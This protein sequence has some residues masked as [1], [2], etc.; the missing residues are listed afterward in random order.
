MLV[1]L[2]GIET[3]QIEIIKTEYTQIQT[4]HITTTAQQ[5]EVIQIHHTLYDELT[6]NQKEQLTG[7]IMAAAGN[8]SYKGKY[9]V[10][11]VLRNRVNKYG[12]YKVLTSG[13][14]E[15]PFYITNETGY[16]LEQRN[17]QL[18][19]ARQAFKIAFNN[20]DYPNLMYYQNPL[21]S[22]DDGLAFFSKLTYVL[23]EGGHNFYKEQ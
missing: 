2:T 3:Q 4:E 9:L 11:C 22:T 16:E 1:A 7:V 5:I 20:N 12:I 17:K 21:Y 15:K 10:A 14:V 8:E 13:H 23:T 6:E 19:D 18:A